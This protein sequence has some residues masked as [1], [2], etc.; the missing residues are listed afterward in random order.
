LASIRVAPGHRDE[1]IEIFKANV[2]NVL[3][4]NG[5]IEYIPTI[6]T[7]TGFESQDLNENM[8]TI[9]EKW[10]S[11]DHLKA[12]L[13]APHMKTYQ[14]NVKDIVVKVGL[15]VLENA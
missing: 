7:P 6:D 11:L 4:E 3:N 10:E 15:K 14:E 9:V 1:F 8:V 12:H 2:P 5:C 13:S